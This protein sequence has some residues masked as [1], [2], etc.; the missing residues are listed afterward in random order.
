[1]RLSHR[2]ACLAACALAI[3]RASDAEAQR[4]DSAW[5][6]RGGSYDGITVPI[7]VAAASRKGRFWRLSSLRGEQR[8][9]GWN[10]S[11]LPVAVAFRRGAGVTAS[12]STAF[13]NILRQLEA[14]IGMHLFEP[15]T[16]MPGD[17]PD[18]VIVVDVKP[19]AADAGLTLVTWSTHGSIYD[20]R[21]YLGSRGLLH[22]ERVVSHEMLH[23]LGFGHTRAWHSLMNPAPSLGSRVTR[24]DVAYIQA[25]LASRSLS[26]R[27]D[28]LSG[29]VLAALREM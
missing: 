12:D 26:E 13:W 8:I 14:D 16:L 5:T 28:R 10:P 23:A 1:M 18:D 6:I 21:I 20:S 27:E 19:M 29:L 4:V 3:S 9:V 15:T 17:D 7:D 24:E 11:R 22:N 25:A 2:L